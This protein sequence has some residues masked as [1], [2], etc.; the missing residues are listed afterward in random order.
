MTQPDKVLPES[1][2]AGIQAMALKSSELGVSWQLR[3]ATVIVG[4]STSVL[5]IYDNDSVAIT[6]T[7]MTGAPMAAGMRVYGV[8][9]PPGGNFI[10]GAVDLNIWHGAGIPVNLNAGSGIG[11]T[12]S[13][14]YTATPGSQ[15]VTFTKIFSATETY[16]QVY[17]ASGAFLSVGTNTELG[18]AVQIAGVDHEVFHQFINPTLTHTSHSGARLITANPG[19]YVIALRWARIGG[20]G[21]LSQ[22]TGTWNTILVEEVPAT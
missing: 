12:T 18:I 3:K 2:A 19:T 16:I 17:V 15:S 7:N 14:S 4:T 22:N 21:T 11:T 1:I 6:M 9:V 8:F 10:V 20:T 5:A 13:A